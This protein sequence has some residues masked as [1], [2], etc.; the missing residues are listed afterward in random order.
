MADILIT[1]NTPIVTD[2]DL[3]TIAGAA[4]PG[5]E[6]YFRAVPAPALPEIVKLPAPRGRC[7]ITS[8]SRS[9]LLEAHERAKRDGRGFV[10]RIRQPGRRRGACFLNVRKLLEFMRTAEAADHA[11]DAAG[12]DSAT[13]NPEDS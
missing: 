4:P 10:F 11:R 3:P 6:R 1:M 13:I 7:P 12:A 5:L 2:H 8:A 9:W